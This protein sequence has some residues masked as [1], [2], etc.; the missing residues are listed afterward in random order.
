MHKPRSRS[1]SRTRGE[2]MPRT[3]LPSPEPWT[4]E[5]WRAAE[6]DFF[7]RLVAAEARDDAAPAAALWPRPLARATPLAPLTVERR[8][9][10]VAERLSPSPLQHRSSSR[11][12][13][14][15]VATRSPSPMS[16]RRG[17]IAAFAGV[18]AL[19]A[20]AAAPAPAPYVRLGPPPRKQVRFAT[21]GGPSRDASR[22]RRD[23]RASKSGRRR[24][25]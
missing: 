7:A 25:Q 3:C 19:Q 22:G 2:L 23:H 4:R 21:A 5:Q 15:R 6:T 24:R 20:A 9:T 11:S 12:R 18:R 10:W 14:R 17:A 13:R 1:S 8:R 16:G